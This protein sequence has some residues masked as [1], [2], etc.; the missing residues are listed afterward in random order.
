MRKK[1]RFPRVS[2]AAT[3]LQIL[4]IGFLSVSVVSSLAEAQSPSNVSPQALSGQLLHELHVWQSASDTAGPFALQALQNVAAQRQAKLAALMESDPGSVIASALPDNVRNAFPSALQNLVEQHVR[5]K[6]KMQ[7]AV[8]DGRNYSRMHYGLLVAG[9]RLT[10]HFADQAPNNLLTGMAVQVEGVQVG[11]ALATSGSMTTTTTTSSTSAST[12]ILPNTFGAQNTAVILVNFQDESIQPFTAS[13]ASGVIFSDAYSASGYY[14]EN[15]FQQTWLTGNVFGWYTIPVSYTTCDVSS[16]A[17]Y[18]QQAATAA[19]VNLS[20]FQRFLYIFPN[21]AC[22]WWGYSY[23]GGTPSQSWIRDYSNSTS[24]LQVMNVSHELGH[25]FGLYHSH[26]LNCGSTTYA[27]TSCSS[28]EY[29]DTLDF[30]GNANYVQGGDFNGFQKERLGWLN[31]GTQPPIQTVTSS[32]TYTLAPYESQDSG[33]K[34]LKILQSGSTN[35]YYYVEL[36]QAQG[37]DNF[38]SSGY[39]EVLNGVV[40]H[41]GVAGSANSSEL[42]NMLPSVTNWTSPALDVANSYT[43]STAGISLTPTAVSSTGASVQ[44]TLSNTPTCTPANPSLSVVS[45]SSSV[46][47]G[48]PANFTVTVT[49]NDSSACGSSSFILGSTVP[50]GWSSAYSSSSLTLAPGTST[51]VTLAVSSPSTATDGTYTV[52]ASAT[53]AS[54][55]TFATSASG[56]ETIYSAPAPSTASSVNVSISTDGTIYF[57]GQTIAI[58][59]AVMKGTTPVAG[60]SVTGTITKSNGSVV[61]LSSTTGSNGVA[62]LSYKLKKQDPAGT[63][64][65]VGAS[66]NASASTTFTV[67]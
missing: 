28:V 22:T 12:S 42:L 11:E 55:T 67:Q 46:A 27:A 62:K 10:L 43:D 13:Y 60:A 19:G 21:N 54:A 17:T 33:V 52:T 20:G 8:E 15:S 66:N 63:W 23:I 58:S 61:S 25:G 4:L 1:E 35:S 34:A 36:R 7:V 40:V 31:Y 9:K 49:D 37:Y 53:N 41:Q 47:P 38:L 39:T 45:P 56:S 50:S 64:N 2:F 6:G 24:G 48:S 57:P 65:A 16:I 18:A 59:V 29:G 3:W 44:V 51:P 30:M 26:A 5:L 32:G 14:L